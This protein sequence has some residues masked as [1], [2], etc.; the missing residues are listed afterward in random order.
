MA[1]HIKSLNIES[2]RGLEGLK[3]ENLGDV[4]IIVGDNNTGKTSVLEAIQFISNP[5]EYNMATIARQREKYKD[6]EYAIGFVDSVRYLFNNESKENNN[7]KLEVTADISGK[8]TIARVVGRDEMKILNFS[9]LDDNEKKMRAFYFPLDQLP[10]EVEEVDIFLG[11]IY[12]NKKQMKQF[13]LNKYN[14]VKKSK[15][16]QALVNVT[17]ISAMEHIA[18]DSFVNIT[19][20]ADLAKKA[21]ELLKG[22]DSRIVDIRYIGE[23]GRKFIPVLEVEGLNEYVPL[24]LFG[25]GMKK[26]LTVLNA[27]IGAIVDAEGGVVLI[28]E[29][30]TSLHTTAMSQVFKFMLD[31]AKELNV[32]L[33]LTTHSLEA[34]DTLLRCDEENVDRI[35]VV[36]IRKHRDQT[37]SKTIIGAEALRIRKKYDME[38]RI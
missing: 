37:Y 24:S 9:E 15:E 1:T 4:N 36:R 2:F 27:I 16:N 6:S 31:I 11:I 21:V 35:K 19:Q 13:E 8:I 32:Q 29:F 7:Y 38:L 5:T 25:D 30:E 12:V 23:G 14:S 34:I 33:F 17:F 22:F 20:R 26:A 28:D 18:K 10:Q 3:I